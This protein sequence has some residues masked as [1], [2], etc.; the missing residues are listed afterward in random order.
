MM[1]TLI[2]I[3]T[4][5]FAFTAQAQVSGNS[6]NWGYLSQTMVQGTSS[7]TSSTFSTANSLFPFKYYSIMVGQVQAGTTFNVA[8]EGSLDNQNWTPVLTTNTANSLG[9]STVVAPA[10]YLR[11]RATSLQAGRT[12]TATAIGVP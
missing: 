5:F 2:V 7:T 12:I 6:R 9:V 1:K 3:L 11:L 10:L 4:F 8:L